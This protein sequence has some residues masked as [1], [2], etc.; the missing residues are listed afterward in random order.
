M[1]CCLSRVLPISYLS[2]LV[3]QKWY[4]EPSSQKLQNGSSCFPS[5]S[6]PPKLGKV[7]F[8]KWNSC[9]ASTLVTSFVVSLHLSSEGRALSAMWHSWSWACL[10]SSAPLLWA[11]PWG[12]LPEP[13]P[14][15]SYVNPSSPLLYIWICCILC[16]DHFHSAFKVQ[17]P[18]YEPS[19]DEFRACSLCPTSP[20]TSP[21]GVWFLVQ[22]RL[23]QSIMFTAS[24]SRTEPGSS[25]PFWWLEWMSC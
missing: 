18:L 16:P 25:E 11:T 7:I 12:P 23:P 20:S 5:V 15:S 2:H 3:R 6:I 9:C 22:L 4:A 17:S 21:L 8:P 19:K 24:M 14:S 13:S 1:Y 10:S